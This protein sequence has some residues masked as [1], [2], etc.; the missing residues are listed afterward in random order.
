MSYGEEG[1]V[2]ACFV[3]RM[4][5]AQQVSQQLCDSRHAPGDEATK[6]SLAQKAPLALGRSESR[7]T[8]L[9]SLALT[10]CTRFSLICSGARSASFL[11]PSVDDLTSP[12]SSQSAS[13]CRGQSW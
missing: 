3:E 13:G 4:G 10:R 11:H 5:G 6:R 9:V 2:S 12:L 8:V 7:T 1:E